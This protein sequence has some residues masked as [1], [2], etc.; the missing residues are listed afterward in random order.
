MKTIIES[1]KEKNDKIA[2]KLKDR[3]LFNRI[4]VWEKDPV[5]PDVDIDSALAQIV[6]KIPK[7]YFNNID[8]IFIG[9]FA[10]LNNRN[11]NALF[12]D[13]AIYISNT[14]LDTNDFIKN[15]IHE[16]AHAVQEEYVD[17]VDENDAVV[18]EFFIKRRQLKKI[19]HLNGYETS[20]Q[21][22]ENVD[23]DEGFDNYLYQQVGY[24]VMHTLTANL[25]VSPY[26]ATS[27]NE[28]FANGFEH[29]YLNDYIS[30][31][32]I[33]PKLFK[34]ISTIENL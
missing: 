21:N 20:K 1:M 28:Y 15:V 12:Q 4:Y 14:L 24:P 16:L 23:Y 17:L 27:Y 26:A 6:S 10:E 3:R 18:D 11:L 13:N 8:S 34:L 22:F 2:K 9:Q 30:V 32:Q 7:S 19:L 29:Y 33:S 5:L 31:K 25:F